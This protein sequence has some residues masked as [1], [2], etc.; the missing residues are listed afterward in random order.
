MLNHALLQV[1]KSNTDLKD[2]L[3]LDAKAARDS[4]SSCRFHLLLQVNTML[5]AQFFSLQSR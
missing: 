1:A 3:R 5:D 2:S 4:R